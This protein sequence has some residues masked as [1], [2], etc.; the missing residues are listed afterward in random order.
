METWQKDAASLTSLKN[1][2]TQ[3]HCE[4]NG[5]RGRPG[6]AYPLRLE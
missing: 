4:Q 6:E 1:V 5:A 2:T 3:E